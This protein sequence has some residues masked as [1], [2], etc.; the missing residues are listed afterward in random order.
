MKYTDILNHFQEKYGVKF[1]CFNRP[2]LCWKIDDLL[3]MDNLKVFEHL[4]EIFF[5]DFVDYARPRIDFA[6]G[7]E[8]YNYMYHFI[9]DQTRENLKNE[10]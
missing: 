5:Q 6:E 8:E 2:P 9:L 10:N 1:S 4:F 3:K 7:G